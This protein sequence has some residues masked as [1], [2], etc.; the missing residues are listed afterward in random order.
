[1]ASFGEKKKVATKRY[2]RFISQGGNQPS[3]W[4]ELKNQIFLGSDKYVEEVLRLIDQTKEL[5]EIPRSQ[6]RGKVKQLKE[7]AL[8]SDSRNKAISEA[9]RSGGY[10][11][12][13]IGIY[14]N[15]HYST[16]SGILKSQRSKT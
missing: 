14:F 8:A 13:E 10:T 16:I 15:L 11:L 4:E 9:Y 5:S 6:R 2:K 7:Y 3:P 1:M 12:K